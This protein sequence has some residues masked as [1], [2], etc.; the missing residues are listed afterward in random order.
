MSGVPPW[1]ARSYLAARSV[2]QRSWICSG[3]LNRMELNHRQLGVDLFNHVW[4]LIEL[5][6]RTPDQDDE[7]IHSAHASA[8]HWSLAPECK[9]EN[10]ARSEWQVAR[11]YAVLGRAE[12]TLWHARRCLALCEEH[13]LTDWDLAFAYESLAR[14]H[15]VAGDRPEADRYI[16]RARE[17]AIAES[18]DRAQLER[19]LETV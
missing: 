17:V 7:L 8:H 19:D 5:P 2:K 15:A 11:A 12:P 3:I 16:T 18:D 6:S 1:P 10:R 14:A 9:P 13:G 4:G